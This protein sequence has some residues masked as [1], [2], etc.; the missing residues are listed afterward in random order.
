MSRIL[1]VIMATA[2]AASI[3]DSALTCSQIV[4]LATELEAQAEK[5]DAT[6]ARRAG[7]A[8]F[9]KGL[10][11]SLASSA[12]GV[13][14]LAFA[15]QGDGWGG[16]VAQQAISAASATAAQALQ[17]PGTAQARPAPQASPTRARLERLV[18]QAAS[19]GCQSTSLIDV[20]SRRPRRR[21]PAGGCRPRLGTSHVR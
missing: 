20:A 4:T 17:D 18:G 11:G 14:P 9:A 19:Q 10:F 2:T 15:G 3:D 21:R 7:Q 6:A 1:L 12:V 16:M 8:R 13:A 5:E